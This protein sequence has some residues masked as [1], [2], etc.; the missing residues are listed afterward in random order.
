MWDK[1]EDDDPTQNFTPIESPADLKKKE[2][3]QE[4]YKDTW[5]K[6]QQEEDSKIK[7][8]QDASNTAGYADVAGKILTNFGNSQKQ[9][10][11]LANRMQD[12]GKQQE[13]IQPEKQKWESVQP[14]FDKKVAEAKASKEDAFK[15]VQRDASLQTID[16]QLSD[17]SLVRSDKATQRDLTAKQNDTQSEASKR[18][19]LLARSAINSKI[20]EAETAGDKDGA[21]QLRS[22]DITGMSSA[23]AKNFYD[24][25]KG[26][27][28][29]DVL[30]N[31][32]ADKRLE[33][34]INSETQ[35]TKTQAATQAKDI[36]F[37]LSERYNND[38]TTKATADVRTAA[39]K[40]EELVRKPTPTNDIA[41]IF[42]YMKANDP[43][44]TVREGE[45]ALAAKSGSLGDKYKT[46]VEQI[47]SGQLTPEKRAALLQSIRIQA[48]AQEKRQQQVDSYY[49]DQ[50][51]AYQADPALI[52]GG[53]RSTYK[54]APQE[55][56]KT[57]KGVTYKKVQGG[58]E[59]I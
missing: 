40:A 54:E 31:Q 26:T 27:D 47:E 3:V 5:R 17:A 23:E 11:Y 7:D 24:S 56:T 14:A 1:P 45:F 36:T 51:Q 50:A 28:Y 29:R 18:A 35:R 30:N 21:A 16:D 55:E 2:A 8:A 22:M 15:G 4:Y 32:S 13:A 52:V 42:N 53:K 6:K 34:Q 46:Y 44:S 19:Q 59:E 25:L 39:S 48:N 9:P 57:V 49:S 33:R 41:L 37:K 38:P 10:V 58:W 12:L 20:K 43:G